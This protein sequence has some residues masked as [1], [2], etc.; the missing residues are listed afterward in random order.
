MKSSVSGILLSAGKSERMGRPKALLE[1]GGRTNIENLLEEYLSSDISELVLVLGFDAENLR[2]FVN[3]RY[4]D[5]RLKI[6]VNERYE[7]G[8]F[9]SLQKGVSSINFQGILIG[10]ID[11]PLIKRNTI[12]KLIENFDG[13]NIVTPTYR[14]KSGHPIILPF[15]LR[16]DI[17]N[18]TREDETLREIINS[19]K[20]LIKKVEIGDESV[21]F[22]MN[23][24]E[25]Y[26]RVKTL[27]RK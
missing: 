22:N 14:G 7:K 6:V 16:G 20:D 1:I 13:N 10:L 21:N 17:L 24:M 2:T 25:D 18:T 12:N 3:S 11:Y 26:E 15:S 5:K 4:K 9:S 23:T 27:W 8:M 19:H